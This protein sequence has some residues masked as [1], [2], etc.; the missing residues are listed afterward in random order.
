MNPRIARGLLIVA[1]FALAAV[2]SAAGSLLSYP[3]VSSP[4]PVAKVQANGAPSSANVPPPPPA[5]KAKGFDLLFWSSFRYYLAWAIVTP[6]ILWLG[7]RVP[8]SRQRWRGPLCLHVLVPIAAA[9]P[10]FVFRLVVNAAFGYGMPSFGVLLNV[11]WMIA[12]RETTAV[13]PIYGIVLS[14]GVAVRYFRE[15]EAKQLLAIELQRSLTAA[16][17]DALRMKMQPHFLFNTLNSIGALAQAGETDAVSQVV[18]RMGTLLRLSMDT[19][20][21]QFVTLAEELAV[22]DEYLAIEEIRFRDRLHVIRRIDPDLRQALV[23]NLILQPLVDNAIAHGLS[24]RLDARVLEVVARRDGPDLHIAVRDDGPGMPPGWRLAV[25]AGRGLRNVR[26]RLAAL[27]G[28]AYKFDV[29]NGTTGGAVAHLCVPFTET[30]TPP[31]GS[32][33]HGTSAYHHR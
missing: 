26:D 25:G 15:Y 14:A 5:P 30:V 22:L 23:P 12:P 29:E 33:D 28:D 9:G 4:S 27:Y 8:F 11:W 1:V 3:S 20:G 31:V 17:L 10:F 16:Q 24:R 7:R 21:R 6:G 2:L 18:E 19:D 32:V 13:I